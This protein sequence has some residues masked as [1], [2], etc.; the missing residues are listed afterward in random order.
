MMGFISD[1]NTF[2]GF[3]SVAGGMDWG[4]LG[5]HYDAAEKKFILPLIG[6]ATYDDLLTKQ[7][8]SSLSPIE[9]EAVTYIQHAAAFYTIYHMAPFM[10]SQMGNLG[11][12]EP[13]TNDGTSGGMRLWNYKET[14][15]EALLHADTIADSLISFLE[16]ND[17]SFSLW[18]TSGTYTI[19]HSNFINDAPTFQKFFNIQSSRRTWMALRPT[20]E[21]V[22]SK[23]YVRQIT[24]KGLYDEILTQIKTDSLS[25]ENGTLLPYIQAVVANATIVESISFLSV[26]ISDQGIVLTSDEELMAGSS[27]AP[28]TGSQKDRI[29]QRASDNTQFHQHE[30]REFLE[31]NADNYTLYRDS[32]CKQSDTTTTDFPGRVNNSDSQSF[33][34]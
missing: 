30:L 28:A 1:T 33:M 5:P 7:S 22:V 31:E 3:Y 23:K 20:M 14:R 13:R 16:E 29:L 25:T 26:R 32:D 11:M 34:F 10:N 19:S 4:M 8:G 27:Q 24:C 9:T 18:K 17:T 12:I 2:I 6:K 15:R 21:N